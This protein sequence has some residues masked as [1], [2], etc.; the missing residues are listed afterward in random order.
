MKN[1]LVFITVGALSLSMSGCLKTRAQLRDEGEDTSRPVPT[2]V[3]D[4]QPKD[5][6]VVEEMKGE[7]TRLTGRLE[8]LE[9]NR[10]QESADK[11]KEKSEAVKAL[12]TRIAEL[13]K[14]Q[15]DMIEALKKAQAHQAANTEAP[16]HFEKGK[17]AYQ[18]K[19]YEEAVE[20]LGNYLKNPKAKDAEEATF[21][22]A[23]SY[24]G[25][26]QYKK[27]I[28]DYSKF[29]EKYTKSKRMP[30]ALFKIGQ[31]F[32]GLGMKE[33]AKGFYQELVDKFPKSAE[34][35]KAKGKLK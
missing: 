11:A 24:Y 10:Q 20:H 4:V 9:R 33:D 29:P 7:I 28:I 31:S 15:A 1:S 2:Q 27:A 32:E 12:E 25:L 30:V 14:A 3:Q 17:K 8:D 16:E 35:K 18:A 22:R 6:Y 13:E 5:S 19:D 23:E 21:L 34:A 26:K